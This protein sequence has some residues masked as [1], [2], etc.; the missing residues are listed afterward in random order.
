MEKEV[1][2]RRQSDNRA[3]DKERPGSNLLRLDASPINLLLSGE[4][5]KWLR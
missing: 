5:K 1:A 2:I 4:E 3:T